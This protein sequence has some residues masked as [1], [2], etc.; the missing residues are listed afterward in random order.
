MWYFPLYRL[1]VLGSEGAVRWRCW[2]S[3]KALSGLV[4]HWSL[5]RW[6]D[7]RE[8]LGL[9]QKEDR[10]L[11]L[12]F[13]VLLRS[14]RLQEGESL[15][16]RLAVEG[17]CQAGGEGK[18]VSYAGCEQNLN[19]ATNQKLV[20]EQGLSPELLT[21]RLSPEA[22]GP[23]AFS[24]ACSRHR[25]K[26]SHWSTQLLESWS[27]AIPTWEGLPWRNTGSSILPCEKPWRREGLARRRCRAHSRI[28]GWGFRLA[29]RSSSGAALVNALHSTG[30]DW[31]SVSRAGW[32]L[33]AKLSLVSFL[34][35]AFFIH[36][37]CYQG[38]F[39]G[40][41]QFPESGGLFWVSAQSWG[42][43]EL[44]CLEEQGGESGEF[45]CVLHYKWLQTRIRSN[46]HYQRAESQF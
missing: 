23:V 34:L 26:V 31:C 37:T 11:T 42:L 8:S 16:C 2:H 6:K 33:C 21:N 18:G 39:G 15:C 12:L 13:C 25:H 10:L 28:L 7:W 45:C 35:R 22:H 1:Q 20:A 3:F 29:S 9:L 24:K 19:W 5:G 27:V 40:S 43:G 36:Y 38:S 17:T 44:L 4:R 30:R 41:N 46:K 14:G 32:M